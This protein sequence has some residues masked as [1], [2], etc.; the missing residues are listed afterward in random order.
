MTLSALAV[1]CLVLATP[2]LAQSGR[3]VR[4]CPTPPPGTDRPWLDPGYSPQCRAEFALATLE[5]TEEKLAFIGGGGFGGAAG[6]GELGLE[7]GRTQDGPAGFNG[8]TA[9][10]TPLSLSASFDEALA[11]RF[12]EAMG[13]EFFESG[14]NG[15]LGP[16]MDPTRTWHFGRSTESYGEDPYLSSRMA[17]REVA[18]IQSQHV[19]TTIKHFAVYTQEQGRLG[20]NPTGERPAVN[21]IVS[22]RAL[23]EIYLPPFRAAIEEGGAGG[24]M[25][26]FPQIN[27]TYACE[28]ERLLTDILKNEWGFD[29][30]VAPDFPVAQRS[31]AAAFAA[32]L[33]T[34]TMTPDVQGGGS[35]SGG[36]FAGDISLAEAVARGI[37]SAERLDDLVLRRLVPGFRIGTFDNP[38]E[39]LRDDPSTD[40]AR[41][42]AAEIASSGAVLLKNDGALPL[43]DSVRRIALIGPQAGDAPVVVEQGSPNVPARHLVTARSGLGA[44]MPQGVSIA[45]EPAGPGLGALDPVP[46]GLLTTPDGE[47]GVRAEYFA[48]PDIRLPEPVWLTRTEAA[49]DLNGTPEIAGLPADKAWAVR[50][51]A[52]FT[53]PASGRHRLRVQGSGSVELRVDGQLEDAFY[54]ADFGSLA[55]ASVE[56]D[57]GDSVELD[58][59]FSPRTT[60]GDAERAQFGTVLGVVARLGYAPPDDGLERARRAAAAA[61]VAIVLAG[62][63]VGEGMDRTSLAL[64]DDQGALIAAVAAANPN[65]VVVLTTGGAV[66]MPWLDDVAAVLELWLPGDAYGTA[67]ARLLYGDVDPGGRLPVTFPASA[68]QGPGQMQATYPGA[69]TSDGAVA[70]V[71]FDE[72]LLVGYRYWDAYEQTP[73]YPF[74]YGLSYADFDV[75]ALGITAT[76]DGGAILR[77]RVQNT[78]ARAGREVLQVYLEFPESAGSPPRQ[79]KGMRSVELAAGAGQ[80]VGIALSPQAFEAWDAAAD[81]WFVPPGTYGVALGLSSRDI[82]ARFELDR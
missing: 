2:V 34:G 35:A 22:E 39:S 79:L 28:N 5:S 73:L 81:R 13:R 14:R 6:L 1:A 65:T 49:I 60:L 48:S 25:C 27:G 15:I 52:R 9:W 51:T 21:Q 59:R 47:P 38:A 31:I 23:R 57:A 62:H 45:V 69:L 72:D 43:D 50:W 76:A 33:D 24:V 82:V 44:R 78:S 74:G 56:L 42:L 4:D 18:G 30:A 3:V 10:P 7:T 80:T 68:A 26:S 8:G 64:P 20:D 36:R 32:G 66:T 17:A 53:A 75:E 41:E 61:D 37:V 70:T 40:A 46:A 12:G 77:A 71:H 11:A 16:A 54:N 63:I 29:G 67:L 58:V 19:M 55:Y